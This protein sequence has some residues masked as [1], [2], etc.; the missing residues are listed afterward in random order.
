MEKKPLIGLDKLFHRD[1]Y[2]SMQT[3]GDHKL[4]GF[5][6]MKALIFGRPF[7]KQFALSYR[8]V[9]LSVLSVT[10]VYCGQTAGWI[11]MPLGSEVGLGP[12]H[13]VLHG[14]PRQT[15]AHLSNC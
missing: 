15:V 9:V 8:T 13:T 11:K 4:V 7:I 1:R 5:G 14:D 6:I 3:F 10:L 12:D 2:P